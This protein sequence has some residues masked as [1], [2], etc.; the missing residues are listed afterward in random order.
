MIVK[1][2]RALHIFIGQPPFYQLSYQTRKKH[3]FNIQDE[4]PVNI[5]VVYPK[6]YPT[7]LVDGAPLIKRGR[8]VRFIT[9]K[10]D[11]P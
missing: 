3:F 10:D 4:K 11:I 6:Q 7:N 2:V 9:P 1:T 8:P 5:P